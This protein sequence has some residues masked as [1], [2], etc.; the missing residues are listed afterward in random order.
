MMAMKGRPNRRKGCLARA[1]RYRAANVLASAADTY[2]FFPNAGMAFT[3]ERE[4]DWGG[5]H[6][7]LLVEGPSH[8]SA[9]RFDAEWFARPSFAK[10]GARNKSRVGTGDGC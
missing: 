6:K 5:G 3:A 8:S 1:A 7:F 9:F 2:F 10:K 4:F